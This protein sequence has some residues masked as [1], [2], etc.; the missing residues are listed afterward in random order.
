MPTTR[1]HVESSKFWTVICRTVTSDRFS[2][3]WDCRQ[4]T[5][6]APDVPGSLPGS[7]DQVSRR[8]WPRCRRSKRHP[9]RQ[10][11]SAIRWGFWNGQI[12]FF[13][14]SFLFRET[15]TT[16]FSATNHSEKL[17]LLSLRFN[18]QIVN[19]RKAVTKAEPR[20]RIVK[21]W[22]MA[23]KNS[24]LKF[25]KMLEFDPIKILLCD[26]NTKTLFRSRKV[27]SDSVTRWLECS[28]N[29][30]AF[31][32]TATKKCPMQSTF[33]QKVGSIFYNTQ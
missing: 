6:L 11:K 1:H 31:T 10:A 18:S 13:N 9:R 23:K 7:P 4:H 8:N 28:F 2:R 5:V 22:F 27:Y 14:L 26:L 21:R 12:G 29:I 33:C 20:I 3:W 17:L 15:A 19:K 16:T 24:R 25:V 32:T 30:W